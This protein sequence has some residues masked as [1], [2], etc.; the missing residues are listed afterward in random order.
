MSKPKATYTEPVN[1]LARGVWDCLD[2]MPNKTATTT[3][4]VGMVKD[5][6]SPTKTDAAIAKCLADNWRF[7]Y[8]VPIENMWHT[9]ATA[10]VQPNTVW[11][12]ATGAEQQEMQDVCRFYYRDGEKIY[13]PAHGVRKIM[14]GPRQSI[15]EQAA[16]SVVVTT[17]IPT[18]PIVWPAESLPAEPKPTDPAKALVT[19]LVLGTLMG[20][21]VMSL[22]YGA[23]FS[24][25]L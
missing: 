12:I 4:V 11:R 22:I 13:L 24:D 20:A 2:V 14:K 17:P 10:P 15:G 9:K 19:G 16:S 7:G 23:L 3:E 21:L 8:I 6:Y 18:K 5:L 25:K 1:G